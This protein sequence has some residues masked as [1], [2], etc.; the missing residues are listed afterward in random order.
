M[1]HREETGMGSNW[2]GGAGPEREAA[3]C[4][5]RAEDFKASP[6]R[7]QAGQVFLSGKFDAA[8]AIIGTMDTV[9]LPPGAATR[10]ALPPPPAVAGLVHH[11][12]IE[13]NSAGKV[14]V[15]ATPLAQ[16]TF[17]I[18]GGS[19]LPPENGRQ[20]LLNRPFLC[21][22]LARAMSAEWQPG[23]TF[24]TALIEPSCFSAL[25]SIPLNEVVNLPV[26]LEDAAPRLPYAELLDRLL[27]TPH[28]AHW[29]ELLSAWLLRLA[30]LREEALRSA[31]RMPAGLLYSPAAAIAEQ[32][33]ISVRQLER[34]FLVSYG[35]TLRDSRRLMRYGQAMAL[36]L[37]RPPVRG[38][39]TRIAMDAGYHD[40]AHMVRDFTE[41]MGQA[42]GELLAAD[43]A[44]KLRLLRYDEASRTA[45]VRGV[46][47]G[48]VG[49]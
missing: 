48:A 44:G 7:V 29:V 11:F 28:A 30:A 31:F 21:G 12:H 4:G 24:V 26:W 49:R 20:R 45:V 38:Q 36:M 22:P 18:E 23:T 32:H 19:L 8:Q 1:G 39:L 14:V 16:L 5:F 17:I 46:E 13:Y 42:P 47:V 25:F 37:T 41:L 9:C 40:Q 43:G 10:L 6:A 34:R 33:G 3:R 2:S 27:A 15:P 35:Q